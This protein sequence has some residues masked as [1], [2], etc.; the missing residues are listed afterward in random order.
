MELGMVGL[1]RMGLNMTFRL[2]RGGHRVVVYNRSEEPRRHAAAEGAVPTASL[3]ELV[4]T[5]QEPRVVWVMLPAGDV[6]QQ[7]L[8][9]LADL[10]APGDLLVDGANSY[11]KDSLRRSQEL[12]ARGLHF[13]DVGVSGGVWGLTEGYCMMVGGSAEDVERLRP[14]LE[15]LAPAPDRGWGHVGP[16]GAGHFT[17]MVH[18]GIEYGLMEAYAEGFAL[19]EAKKEFEL[20][21]HQVAEIWQHGSV[22]RSWLLELLGRALAE[23]ASLEDVIGE[24]ADCGE[25]RWTV[26]EGIEQSLSIPVITLSLL[27]RFRSREQ[28]PYSDRLLAVL[29][30]QFGGHEVKRRR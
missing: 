8:D 5:L 19:L 3:E 23:E 16:V 30:E 11:Y 27:R 29:R 6:T 25:G 9:R 18:N 2:L 13:V 20:D 28:N 14:A 26:L 17:K 12:G 21:L 22:V 24:V 4:A 1:G 10:L 15:T 7:H